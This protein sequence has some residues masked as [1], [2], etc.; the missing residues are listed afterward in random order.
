MRISK[1]IMWIISNSHHEK[2]IIFDIF[3]IHSLSIH[4][5]RCQMS[6]RLSSLFQGS[7]NQQCCLYNDFGCRRIS[8]TLQYVYCCLLL[9]PT[10][11]SHFF[12]PD[13]NHIN[14]HGLSKIF[15]ITYNHKNLSLKGC[16]DSIIL[17]IYE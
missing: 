5:K 16:N 9:L 1:R 13:L 4:E 3:L 7:R 12:A 10:K 17:L 15:F 11:I 2:K 8:P 14:F 6:V